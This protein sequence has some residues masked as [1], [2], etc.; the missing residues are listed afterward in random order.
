MS[1]N[2]LVPVHYFCLYH[3]VELSF[4]DSLHEYGLINVTVID[5]DKFLQ[6]EELKQI[7]KFIQFY[8]DLGI[9]VEGIDVITNL[10]IQNASLRSELDAALKKLHIFEADIMQD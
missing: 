6:P 3:E 2:N 4:I 8:Y 7:E 5:E 10:L 9:N 1:I